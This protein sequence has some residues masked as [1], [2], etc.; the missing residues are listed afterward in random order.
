MFGLMK[1][2]MH[3]MTDLESSLRPFFI[4]SN[5]TESDEII[6]L[7]FFKKMFS[8]QSTAETL[9][10][11]TK[12]QCELHSVSRKGNETFLVSSIRLQSWHSHSCWYSITCSTVVPFYA[13]SDA[14]FSKCDGFHNMTISHTRKMF[15]KYIPGACSKKLFMAVIYWFS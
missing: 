1:R 9:L 4:V 11:L 5:I 8:Q 10:C 7:T 6:N 13:N 14:L 15:T 2:S 3:H 12:Y